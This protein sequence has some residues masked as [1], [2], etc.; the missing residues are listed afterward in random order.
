M[1]NSPQVAPTTPVF[2][3]PLTVNSPRMFRNSSG[4][5]TEFPPFSLGGIVRNSFTGQQYASGRYVVRGS[6]RTITSI[7]VTLSDLDSAG[8]NSGPMF[9]V[10]RSGSIVY[11]SP[12]ITANLVTLTPSPFTLADGQV[13]WI[14]LN[15]QGNGD[16]TN[17][18][19]T[20]RY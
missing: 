9:Q 17:L 4:A 2:D 13:V 18:T 11:S 14:Q 12:R 19:V 6:T 15:N 3:V 5:V 16:A 10:Y 8:V 7:D 20:L 1:P